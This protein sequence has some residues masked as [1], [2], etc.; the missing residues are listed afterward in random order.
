MS[1][2][3]QFLKHVA[4]VTAD[5]LRRG[6]IF[7]LDGSAFAAARAIAADPRMSAH[8]K[9]LQIADAPPKRPKKARQFVVRIDPNDYRLPISLPQ[10]CEADV[11]VFVKRGCSRQAPLGKTTNQDAILAGRMFYYLDRRPCAGDFEVVYATMKDK[12]IITLNA[13]SL[14]PV[15]NIAG[16]Y[17][18]RRLEADFLF[19]DGRGIFSMNFAFQNRHYR[20]H[21]LYVTVP[22]QERSRI[23]SIGRPSQSP[24]DDDNTI[25][26]HYFDLNAVLAFAERTRAAGVTFETVAQMRGYRLIK[27]RCLKKGMKIFGQSLANEDASF[28]VGTVAFARAS[29]GISI[30][31]DVKMPFYRLYGIPVFSPPSGLITRWNEVMVP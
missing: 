31:G 7:G 18:E 30:A 15:Q 28:D 2:E 3:K 24:A 21:A 11:E 10:V 1:E 4:C 14:I 25:R 13:D 29:N 26:K 20:P 19:D 6:D 5:V 23:R 16:V 22:W 17:P 8:A 27:A 9:A 12:R